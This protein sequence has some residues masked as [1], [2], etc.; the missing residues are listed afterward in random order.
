VVARGG[1][2]PPTRG[3]S[4]RHRWF[5]GLINQSLT[6]LAAPHPRPTK[7]H[8]WHTKYQLVTFTAHAVAIGLRT[9]FVDLLLESSCECKASRRESLSARSRRP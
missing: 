9:E 6:A 4:V 7:A 3:F 1:I 8:S 2:E 5:Y